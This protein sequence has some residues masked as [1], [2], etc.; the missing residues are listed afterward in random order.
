M[1]YFL[2]VCNDLDEEENSTDWVDRM[3]VNEDGAGDVID[4]RFPDF[5]Q[6]MLS[7]KT[8]FSKKVTN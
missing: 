8:K 4:D 1:D 6:E 7:Y 2:E 3:L 5:K